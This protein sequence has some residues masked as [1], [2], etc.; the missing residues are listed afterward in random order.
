MGE[1]LFSRSVITPVGRLNSRNGSIPRVE[2]TPVWKG[3]AYNAMAAKD[4]ASSVI[5]E[6]NTETALAT[7]NR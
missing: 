2:N 5:C 7:H 6:P 1:H 3:E 4:S